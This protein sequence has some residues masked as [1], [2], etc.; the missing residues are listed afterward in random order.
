MITFEHLWA[1]FAPGSFV[2]S[3][4]YG[5]DCLYRLK[6]TNETVESKKKYS[7]LQ[8]GYVDHDGVGFGVATHFVAI[9]KF[10]GAV[11]V[12]ALGAYPLDL[13]PGGKETLVK[14]LIERGK[15]F[16]ALAG[17]A[18]YKDYEGMAVEGVDDGPPDR[19]M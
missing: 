9:P 15:R 4:T 6:G 1:I 8:C 3:K 7:I 12:S 10:E 5:E 16:E 14:T 17:E 2:F 11:Y 13:H 18:R 19:D